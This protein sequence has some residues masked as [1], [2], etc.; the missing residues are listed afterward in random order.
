MPELRASKLYSTLDLKSVYH[1]LEL[2]KE[3]RGFTAFITHE[4]LYQYCRVPYGLSSAPA[5]FQKMK[6]KKILSGLEGVH[7]YLDNVIVYSSLP[8][9]HLNC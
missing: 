2:H 7:C 3:S 8:A 6:M 9:H 5:A 4:G 1:Q